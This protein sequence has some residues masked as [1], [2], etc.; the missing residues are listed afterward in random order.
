M[1]KIPATL[2]RL[3]IQRANNRCEYCG[4]SQVGQVATFHIDHIIP[5]VAGGETTADNLDLACVSCSLRKGARQE[6]EDPET[7]E[8]V[9]IFN[10]RQ[11]R[12]NTHFAGNGV[13][14]IVGLTATGRATVKVLNLNRSTMLA[15]R[16]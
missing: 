10:P 14:A 6:I 4:I 9:C 15:I 16:A 8:V 11:Q 3:V 12:W 5:V 7:G 2:R 13:E 1:T